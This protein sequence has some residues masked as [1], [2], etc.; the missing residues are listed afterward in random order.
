MRQHAAFFH[1]RLGANTAEEAPEPL[2]RAAA[3]KKRMIG[4]SL[5]L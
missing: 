4:S 1:D 5:T 3:N 2:D